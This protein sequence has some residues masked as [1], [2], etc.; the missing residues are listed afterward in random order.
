MPIRNADDKHAL[1]EALGD[2]FRTVLK[3][4]SECD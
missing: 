3:P 1:I 4:K 2:R